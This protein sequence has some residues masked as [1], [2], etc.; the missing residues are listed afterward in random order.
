MN[1]PGG[2]DVRTRVI[3]T[4]QKYK[5]KQIDVARQTGNI[6]PERVKYL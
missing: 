3:E 4:L 1:Q 2:K 5:I 6:L